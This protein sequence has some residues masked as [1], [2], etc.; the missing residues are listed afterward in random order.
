MVAAAPSGWEAASL[1][2]GNVA[3]QK[4]LVAGLVACSLFVGACAPTN[5]TGAIPIEVLVVLDS[6]AGSLLLIPVDSSRVQRTISLDGLDFIPTVLDARRDIA[7]VAGRLPAAGAAVIDLS[8][9]LIVSQL[10]LLQGKVVAVQVTENGQAFVAVSTGSVVSNIDLETGGQV[11]IGVPGG[12]QGFAVTRGKV[13]AVVGNR[14]GCEADPVGCSRGPSW[15][16]QVESTFPRDSIPLSGPGNAG[17]AAVGADGY[18]YVISAGDD[19]DGGEG[20]LSVIDPVRNVEI[21]A[22]S[23]VGPVE[24]AWLA[25]DGGDRILIASPV[26]GIMVFDTRERRLTL[27]FGSGIPLEFP[28]DMLTDALG[29]AYVL[30]RG[31]CTEANGGRIRVFG[32]ELI[33]QQPIVGVLCP[34]AGAMAEVPAERIFEPQS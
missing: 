17:P 25:T 14:A 3:V 16:I 10:A 8:T 23:G 2:E 31:G 9:G 30:Q 6:T 11:L 4:S 21:A 26:G 24:P 34:I 29:R 13:F 1:T 28:T 18:V 12:P 32:T 19:F 22:F 5:S 27:P 33:E 7:V 20:R 15:L